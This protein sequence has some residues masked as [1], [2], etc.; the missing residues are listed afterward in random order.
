MRRPR[1]RV[2]PLILALAPILAG[3]SFPV[4]LA[5]DP[6]KP[7]VRGGFSEGRTGE[8]PAG[9]AE[10]ITDETQRAI[11]QGLRWLSAQQNADGSYGTG[12]YRGNVA[13]TSLAA[14]AMM[15]SGSSPGRGPYG[16]QIDA[17]LQYILEN[18]SGTRPAWWPRPPGATT[19]PC[20]ATDSGP[21]SW[22]KPTA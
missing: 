10:L 3:P 2:V 14:L 18:T 8:I 9:A 13:V 4:A 11:D 7:S 5:D 21:C 19:S 6:A 20:T 1:P 17:A 16:K 12:T 22:P 15:A